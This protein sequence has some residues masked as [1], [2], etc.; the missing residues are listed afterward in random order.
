MAVPNATTKDLISLE[1]KILSSRALST[2]RI[3]PRKGKMA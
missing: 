1:L 3:F 2:L